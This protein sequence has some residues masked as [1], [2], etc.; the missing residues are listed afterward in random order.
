[1]PAGLPMWDA[2][3]LTDDGSQVGDGA[4]ATSWRDMGN[5]PPRTW[6]GRREDMTTMPDLVAV[7]A[8]EVGVGRSRWRC[9]VRGHGHGRARSPGSVSVTGLHESVTSKFNF[10]F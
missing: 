4:I 2:G 3:N 5:G 10:Q 7:E 6:D 8:E 9:A 1:V